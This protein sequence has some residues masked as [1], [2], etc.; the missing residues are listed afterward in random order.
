[1]RP[2]SITSTRSASATASATSCVTRIAV[3]PL[4]VPDALQQPLHLDPGQRV[5]RAERLV[6]RQEAADG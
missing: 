3:K 6:E 2:S 4:F 5:E 1:M